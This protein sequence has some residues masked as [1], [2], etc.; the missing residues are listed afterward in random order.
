MPEGEGADRVMRVL[1]EL[2]AVDAEPAPSPALAFVLTMDAAGSVDITSN[3]HPTTLCALLRLI[4]MNVAALAQIDAGG[5]LFDL[6][7]AVL[8]GDLPK[9]DVDLNLTG[10]PFAWYRQVGDA[11]GK[12]PEEARS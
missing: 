2:A 8:L 5:A 9:V 7:S 10:Q 12:L 11:V 3:V 4:A 1:A 6:L